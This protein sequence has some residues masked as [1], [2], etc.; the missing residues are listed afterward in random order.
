M[1]FSDQLSRIGAEAFAELPNL[2][3]DATNTNIRCFLVV[4]GSYIDFLTTN[5]EAFDENAEFQP[6]S[7]MLAGV[8]SEVVLGTS[9]EEAMASVTAT[10]NFE[11]GISKTVALADLLVQVIPDMNE[12]GT[13]TLIAVYNKTTKGNSATAKRRVTL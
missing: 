7:M 6:L 12:L 2:N 8:P 3:S 1:S 11:G 4:E 9:F 13:K 10:V 5:I